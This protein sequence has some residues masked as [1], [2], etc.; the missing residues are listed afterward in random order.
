MNYLH[1]FHEHT[2]WQAK[3]ASDWKNLIAPT[4]ADA[5]TL[6]GVV[7]N[8]AFAG[9]SALLG[10]IAKL[11]I[12]SV[13]PEA[14]FAWSAGK[15]TMRHH[16]YGVMQGVMWSL[17]KKMFTDLGSRLT[18]SVALSLIP[19]ESQRQ[20]APRTGQPTPHCLPLLAHAVV[21]KPHG[22]DEDIW[23]P[24]RREFVE[25]YI[26]PQLASE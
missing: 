1:P 14:D 15:I 21:Y 5:G 4:I 20:P 6:A 19:A 2:S 13:P 12:N 25:L 3:F 26:E 17:P 24:G 23:V 22:A 9:A 7:P 10:A 11:Q 18:G 8:P 16:Q